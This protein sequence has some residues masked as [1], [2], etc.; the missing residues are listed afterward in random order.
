MLTADDLSANAALQRKI[1][2]IQASRN[3]HHSDDED[4]SLRSTMNNRP[5]SIAS[6]SGEDIDDVGT[7]ARKRNPVKPKPEPS[8]RRGQGMGSG[9]I[10]R[11]SAAVVDLG[12]GSDSEGEV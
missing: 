1:K 2:R 4:E 6:D 11:S 7:S 12:D 5:E 9:A 3:A 10:P 8:T